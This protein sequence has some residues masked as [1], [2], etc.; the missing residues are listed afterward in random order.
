MKILA[1]L[2]LVFASFVTISA[3]LLRAD[4]LDDAILALMQKRNVPGLSLAVVSEGKIV[5]ARGYG[6][7][8][9]GGSTPVTE[10]TLFQ[11]GSISKPVAAFG[12]L[13]LVD[14]GKLSLDDD[15]NAAL[16][17]W[18]VSENEFTATEKVTLR[19]LL[20]HTAGLTVH[21]F[22]GYA[23]DAAQPTLVQILNGEK[24]ANTPAIRADI[25]PDSRWRYSGGGYTVMQQLVIDV[26]GRAY[27]DFMHD[28]VLN[29]LGML[30]SSFEQPLPTALAAKTATGHSQ[31]K[32]VKGRWH[33]YP[34]MAA[35]GLW[36]TASD[37]ARFAIA[38]QQ[39]VAGTPGSILSKETA[40]LMVTPGKGGY[41]FGFSMSSSGATQRFTHGGRDQGFDAQFTAYRETGQA[42][43]VPINTNENSS[44]MNRVMT[45]IGQHYNW[46]DYA[47]YTPP[48]PIEDTEP[49]ITSQVKEIFENARTGKYEQELYSEKLA[50]ILAEQV[51]KPESIAYLAGFGAFKSIHLV[52]KRVNDGNR[53]YR[54]LIVFENESVLLTCTYQPDGKIG[55]LQFQPE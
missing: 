25:T 18:K 2:V 47:P 48:K 36:T 30:A 33:I 19:R 50:A 42:A 13:C 24:P 53:G 10:D 49:D 32:P 51:P 6:V 43:V 46:P 31:R 34:E 20:S 9:N 28:T 38:M 12:A 35:A 22:P 44:F 21:G 27:P 39:S 29:P 26:T 37:L 5:R 4:A 15:V 3:P 1:R 11:A 55:G 54:Y 8:E 23:I 16:K 41:G 52:G 7:I 17:S 14:A 40:Q 45:S